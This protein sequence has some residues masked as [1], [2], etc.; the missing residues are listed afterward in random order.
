MRYSARGTGVAVNNASLE[1][2][3]TAA[4]ALHD[5]ALL[6]RYQARLAALPGGPP[7]ASR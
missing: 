1:L 2:R 7:A 6:S 5:R 4:D 3:R